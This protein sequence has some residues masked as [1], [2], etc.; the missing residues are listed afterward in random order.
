MLLTLPCAGIIRTGSKGC[1]LTR[2]LRMD[3]ELQKQRPGPLALASMLRR[4]AAGGPRKGANGHGT[5]R[6]RVTK[7][8]VMRSLRSAVAMQVAIPVCS[9]CN[10]ELPDAARFCPR[11]G[12]PE[13]QCRRT[14]A[15]H[16]P[17]TLKESG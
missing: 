14:T 7:V 11:C 15:K 2:T 3:N 5:M 10:S 17:P 1:S 16:P 4:I 8:L 9:N 6:W 12:T 13:G